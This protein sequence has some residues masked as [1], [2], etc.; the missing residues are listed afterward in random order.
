MQIQIIEQTDDTLV[1]KQSVT[2]TSVNDMHDTTVHSVSRRILQ[3]NRVLML[4][5]SLTESKGSVSRGMPAVQVITKGCGKITRCDDTV[6]GPAASL[7]QSYVC[8]VPNMMEIPTDSESEE[9]QRPPR[10]RHTIGLLTNLIISSY[11]Q[12]AQTVR[13]FIEN[14]LFDDLIHGGDSDG[15]LASVS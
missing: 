4:W 1:M 12:N 15:R 2:S 7:L 13:Q 11:Q 3:E 10:Q 14:A 8:V 5:E 9:D 6:D